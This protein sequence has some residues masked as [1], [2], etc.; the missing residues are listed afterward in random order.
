MRLLHYGKDQLFHN[1]PRDLVVTIIH[2]NSMDVFIYQWYYYGLVNGN[3]KFNII[4][5]EFKLKNEDNP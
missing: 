1:A 4:N 3:F 5:K 2:Y